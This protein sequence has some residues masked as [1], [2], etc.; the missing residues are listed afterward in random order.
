MFRVYRG[1]KIYHKMIW[2]FIGFMFGVFISQ[3]S[4]QFPNMKTN[5][6]KLF[7]FL[8]EMLSNDKATLNDNHRR[9]KSE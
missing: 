4:P 1:L 9:S 5:F 7:M 2:F 6:L 8:S 3:E